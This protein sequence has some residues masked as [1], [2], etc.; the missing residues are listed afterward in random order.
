[1][2]MRGTLSSVATSTS[3]AEAWMLS[4]LLAASGT[5]LLALPF[6]IF[7]LLIRVGST[8]SGAASPATALTPSCVAGVRGSFS[9]SIS[10]D[11]L[12]FWTGRGDLGA[13]L[14]LNLGMASDRD[15]LG[16]LAL[17]RE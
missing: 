9:T 12:T 14:A 4:M 3:G 10:V 17:E 6:H 7:F 16:A 1:M 13:A 15:D 11:F 5:S 2:P 8:S